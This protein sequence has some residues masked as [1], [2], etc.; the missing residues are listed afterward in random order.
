[1]K[2][3]SRI[4]KLPT[5]VFTKVDQLKTEY[6]QRGIDVIDMSMGNPDGH[7]PAPIV[8]ALIQAAKQPQTHRYVKPSK[9]IDHFRSA[10]ATWYE[11]NYGV[12]LEINSEIIATIGAKE[13]I[14]HLALA[15]SEAHDCVLVPSPSYPIHTYAFLIAGA[16]V[17]TFSVQS[18]QKMLA[19]IKQKLASNKNI[20]A[21]MLNFPANPTGH[22]VD[23]GFFEEIIALAKHY[24]TWIIHDFAYADLCFD[25]FRAPSIL[26]VKGAKEVAVEICSLSKSYN[27]PGWRVGYMAGNASLI[28]AL[29][30]IKAYYDYGIFAPIQIAAA[31]ALLHCNKYKQ[32]ICDMYQNRRDV[33]CAG[34]EN[35]SWP[36]QKPKATMFVWAPIPEKFGYLTSLEFTKIIL[37]RAHV[38]VSPGIGFGEAG[39]NA[40]RFALIENPQRIAEAMSRL[41]AFMRSASEIDFKEKRIGTG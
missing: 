36:V 11:R 16:Q 21:I 3:F 13:G 37:D 35:I 18:E 6:V 39:D 12:D 22:C 20:K 17:D 4:E 19:E 33:L 40:I 41:E 27:M 2:P 10:I 31:E 26:Q 38:V 15:I 1:M 14:S 29:T 7:T 23:I 9:G 8:N 32:S 34:L 30:K 28:S 25:G 5:Y 24:Q